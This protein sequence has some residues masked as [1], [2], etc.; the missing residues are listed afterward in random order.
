MLV[1]R[2]GIQLFPNTTQT[3]LD[4]WFSEHPTLRVKHM[5]VKHGYY[6]FIVIHYEEDGDET[7]LFVDGEVIERIFTP[8]R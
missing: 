5:E 8:R 7:T 6:P 2:S 3:E 4:E 1:T